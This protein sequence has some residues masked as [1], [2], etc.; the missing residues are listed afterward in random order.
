M[1]SLHMTWVFLAWWYS[2]GLSV[3]E[4]SIAMAFVVFTAFATMGTGEH[5]AIDLMVA[6]PFAVFLKGLCALGLRWN[7]RSRVAATLYGLALTLV[8]IGALRF[9]P[10]VFWISSALPWTCCILTIAS[11]ILVQRR[12]QT[13]LEG[14]TAQEAVPVGNVPVAVS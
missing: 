13:A 6:F 12:L 7:D 9:A 14:R 4:R 3:W 11:A 8:W 2:R 5:Y 10:K 1:P